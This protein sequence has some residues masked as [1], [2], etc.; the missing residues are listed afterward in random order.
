VNILQSLEDFIDEF[1]KSNNEDFGIDSIRIEFQKQHKLEELNKLG[2]WEKIPK[3]S[4]LLPKLQKRLT[5]DEITSVWRLGKENI[6]YYNMQDAPKYRKATL[7]IFGMKQYHQKCPQKTLISKLL[8]ILKDVSNLDICLDLTSKPNISALQQ[9]YDL[10]Q[11]ITKTGLPTDT[12]YIND[13]GIPSID[14]IV[15]YDKAFKNNLSNELW[16]IEAKV[17]VP[18]INML[19]LPLYELKE[20]TDIL[21]TQA[22]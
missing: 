12:Y 15:I 22:L 11:Y 4:P 9:H 18:N 6:Y 19:A 13:T 3:N 2:K 1:N 20:I 10:T 17:L 5:N 7:V 8:S 16:R 21:R 14:T